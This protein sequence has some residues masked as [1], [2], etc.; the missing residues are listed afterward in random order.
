MLEFYSS[1]ATNPRLNAQRNLMGRT[2]YVDPDSLRFHKS[3][4]L[5]ARHVDGGLLFAITCRDALDFDATSY[6]YRFVI[7][8]LNGHVVERTELEGAF[9]SHKAATKAMWET[10]NKLDA[11]ALTIA[12]IRRAKARAIAE[13]DELLARVA[14]VAS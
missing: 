4:V 3:R 14:K 10:L 13:Y 6:G 11:K 1:K 2:H 12:G 7:F 8:D 9:K 5:S